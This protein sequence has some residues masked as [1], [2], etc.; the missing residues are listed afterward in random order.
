MSAVKR[1]E[2]VNDRM[3]YI[4]L[5][6]SWFHR[7]VLNVHV[8]IDNKNGNIK[9]TIYEEFEHV[10]DKLAKYHMAILLGDFSA[11]EGREYIFKPTIGN[12]SLHLISNANGVRVINFVTY[13]N[14]TVQKYNV[15][16]L[17]HSKLYLDVS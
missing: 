11:K 6:S 17:Q 10:Y 16:T 4:I 5:I 1:V 2:F 3:S 14:L 13:K 12:E 7:T 9:D 8:P 15:S